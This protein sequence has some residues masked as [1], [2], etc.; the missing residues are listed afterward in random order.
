MPIAGSGRFRLSRDTFGVPSNVGSSMDLIF[1]SNQEEHDSRLIPSHECWW[2]QQ[3]ASEIPG[4]RIWKRPPMSRSYVGMVVSTPVSRSRESWLNPPSNKGL[5]RRLLLRTGRSPSSSW[6][7]PAGPWRKKIRSSGSGW[8]CDR[9]WD[10]P[11][12]GQ[13]SPKAGSQGNYCTLLSTQDRDALA[14][15]TGHPLLEL[16]VYLWWSVAWA[17]SAAGNV[18]RDPDSELPHNCQDMCPSMNKDITQ[19]CAPKMV[20]FELNIPHCGGLF[21]RGCDHH[22]T[23]VLLC[24]SLTM[25]PCRAGKSD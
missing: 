14:Y 13:S 16:P 24:Y 3:K 12:Y 23:E 1:G 8:A 18:W 20:L 22:E 4:P 15:E 19:E 10:S 5:S 25:V 7:T 2:V 11:Q 17:G 21:P 9:F 6:L